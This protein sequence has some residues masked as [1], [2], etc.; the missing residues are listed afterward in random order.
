[1]LQN[2]VPPSHIIHSRHD[3]DTHAPRQARNKIEHCGVAF[4]PTSLC[5]VS[6]PHEVLQRNNPN[7]RSES[8]VVAVKNVGGTDLLRCC[9][10]YPSALDAR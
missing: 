4:A 1:M 2:C 6:E 7:S 8:L 10:I 9:L 3:P 5:A